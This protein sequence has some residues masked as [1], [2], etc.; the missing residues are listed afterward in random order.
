MAGGLV[1]R[2]TAFARS[3]GR[4]PWV[5]GTLYVHHDDIRFDPR[6]RRP[7]EVATHLI[8]TAVSALGSSGDG[9][10]GSVRVAHDDGV[11]TYLCL[12]AGRF[13][14]TIEA[15]RLRSHAK[16]PPPCAEASPELPAARSLAA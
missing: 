2:K 14:R 16:S 10:F 15:L 3:G 1:C 6:T 5:L 12:G 8:W 7:V 9:L 11:E 4:G 13:A